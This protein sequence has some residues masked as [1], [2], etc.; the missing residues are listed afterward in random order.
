MK[1]ALVVHDLHER[2]GHSRY[3][4]TLADTL[5]LAHQVK[6]F[7]NRCER[8]REARWQF[9]AVSASRL[10][11]LTLVKTFPWGL[12]VRRRELADFEIRHAQGYC[13]GDPNVVTAHICV[14]AYLDS[15]S[16]ASMR[17]RVSLGLMAE[18]ERRFYRNYRGVVI[19]ISRMVA[20]DLI[21]RYG[22]GAPIRIIPHGVDRT[23][24]HPSNRET[25][26]L[27]TRAEL[28]I[29]EE[30]L[31]AM[32]AGDLTK[33]H[34]HLK[35]LSAAEPSLQLIILTGSERYRWSAPNVRFLPTTA[36][37]EK[38]Y[39]AADLFVFP[40]T[41]DAFGMVALEA[42]AAGLPVFCSDRAGASELIEDGVNGRVLQ[43]SD[44]LD[45]T[46][47]WLSDRS[48][49]NAVGMKAAQTCQ[50]RDWPSVV[51]AVEQVYE[52]LDKAS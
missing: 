8:P 12:R 18:S 29:N 27:A 16:D 47:E 46:L 7:A 40:T 50:R 28:G 2:G 37:I 43:L 52:E 39:A 21:E 20:R 5:S 41:Y 51:A 35:Q 34:A 45:G 19:A 49:L 4:R 33:A 42:M 23:R 24:F 15:L 25:H 13:G 11:A 10:S 32:Y 31:L 9:K 26:R 1:I 14:A 30:Q 38:Y 48:R 17:D 44:W 22:V 36:C 6:V 3:T